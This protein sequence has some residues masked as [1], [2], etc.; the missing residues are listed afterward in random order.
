MSGETGLEA[1]A[2]VGG[3]CPTGI[4]GSREAPAGKSEVGEQQVGPGF[5]VLSGPGAVGIDPRGDEEPAWAVG[6][7]GA[8]PED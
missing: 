5:R 4:S 6:R 2:W 8:D 7:P 3:G 1:E